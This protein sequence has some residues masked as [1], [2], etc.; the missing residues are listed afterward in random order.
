VATPTA[1]HEVVAAPAPGSHIGDPGPLGLAG[2]A[3]TTFFLM[4]VDVGW[5]NASVTGV[6][7]GMA[8]FYGGLGQIIAGIW[9]FAK[10]NAFGGVAFCSYGGFWLSYWYIVAHVDLSK[11]TA[12]QANAGI[13]MFLL[14]QYQLR[15]HPRIPSFDDHVPVPLHRRFQQP[16]GR[17]RLDADRWLGRHCHGGAGVVRVIRWRV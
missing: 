4:T 15:D 10:G 3:M 7:L 14:A 2:F 13:G 9:E 11:A 16:G 17:S 1:D 5:L 12:H 8:I 6:V